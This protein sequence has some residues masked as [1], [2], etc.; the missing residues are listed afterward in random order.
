MT[1]L[2]VQEDLLGAAQASPLQRRARSAAVVRVGTR[3]LVSCCG[4]N[5]RAHFGITGEEA[6]ELF[7]V[8][9]CG[10]AKCASA[11]AEYVEAL[12]LREFPHGAFTAGV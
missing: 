7:S 6:E 8:W 11:A 12:A 9:G 4:V 1:E 10:F 2:S 5:V 3:E